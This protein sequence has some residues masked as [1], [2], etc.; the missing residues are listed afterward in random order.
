VKTL[1]PLLVL[2]VPFGAYIATGNLSGSSDSLPARYLPFSLLRELDF[3]LDEFPA[4]TRAP[5]PEYLRAPYYLR[6]RSGHY[7]SAFS[8][9]PALL[10]L[11]VYA[12]PVLAGVSPDSRWPAVLEKTSASLIVALSVVVL[13]L[14]ARRSSSEGPALAAAAVYAFA[15]SCFSVTSQALWEH[16]PGQLCLAVGLWALV[17]GGSAGATLAGLALAGAVVMRPANVVVA[18]PLFLA[19]LVRHPAALRRVLLAASVP[20]AFLAVYNTLYYGAP[21]SSGRNEILGSAEWTRSPLASLAGL[22]VSPGRGLFVYSPVLIF[23]VAGLVVGCRRKRPLFPALAAASGLLL[24]ALS[25]RRAW[26]GGWCYG[27]RYLAD[28]LPVLCFA[29][30]PVLEAARSR[31]WIRAAVLALALPSVALHGL[32][33]FG[34]DSSWDGPVNV[35]RNPQALWSWS[36]GPIPHFAGRAPASARRLHAALRMALW[37]PP[38]SRGIEGLAASYVS[39]SAPALCAPGALIRL[40]VTAFNNGRSVW[41][42]GTPGSPGTVRLGWIWWCGGRELEA[43]WGRLDMTHP[44]FPGES[45]EFQGPVRAPSP[46]GDCTLIAGLVSEHVAW[47]SSVGTPAVQLP[48]AVRE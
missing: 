29:L 15:T 40:R 30:L 38:T 33:A 24:L 20:V 25:L 34:Y 35:D 11:P 32:G 31:P 27:P 2:L 44:I 42:G 16:G 3:D 6:V 13:Y 28:L 48:V 14:A 1:R 23:A 43:P 10:A 39:P 22:L 36:A 19:A 37:R 12:A 18:A 46:G 21:W 45:F 47:F 4:L 5:H 8:P 26:W 41:L 7:V 9:G 17:R